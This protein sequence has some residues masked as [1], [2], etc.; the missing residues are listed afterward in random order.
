MELEKEMEEINYEDLQPEGEPM[1]L[2]TEYQIPQNFPSINGMFHTGGVYVN[3]TGNSLPSCS[4]CGME[5]EEPS[6]KYIFEVQHLKNKRCVRPISSMYYIFEEHTRYA[7]EDI[8]E[9]TGKVLVV[10]VR[11]DDEKYF[12]ALTNSYLEE[13]GHFPQDNMEAFAEWRKSI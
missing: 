4:S 8:G 12:S 3:L 1:V 6:D 13:S 5:I 11:S 2:N 10:R 9:G 7:H